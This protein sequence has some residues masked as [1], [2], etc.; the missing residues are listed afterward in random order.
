[1][2]F[3]YGIN[4]DNGRAI[5]YDRRKNFTSAFFS[6]NAESRTD[7]MHREILKLLAN[8]NDKIY[9]IVPDNKFRNTIADVCC[10]EVVQ[11]D[12]NTDWEN[13]Q[14]PE[15]LQF[16]IFLIKTSP[17]YLS[18]VYGMVIQ[19]IQKQIQKNCQQNHYS[20]IYFDDMDMTADDKKVSQ[21]IYD[22]FLTAKNQKCFLTYTAENFRS[23][24][25]NNIYLDMIHNTGFTV[26]FSHD[27]SDMKV[28]DNVYEIEEEN[29]NF[30]LTETARHGLILLPDSTEFVPFI[31]L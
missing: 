18:E 11:C 1:M 26:L 2:M 4:Y 29:R 19:Q 17:L 5:H 9:L 20:W 24:H 6:G 28:L 14:F 10:T 8:T 31:M 16:T 13:F 21:M 30:L 15:V 27:E 7:F 12:V 22:L 23:I 25:E 3:S